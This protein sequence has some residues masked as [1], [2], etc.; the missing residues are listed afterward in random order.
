[1]IGTNIDGHGVPIPLTCV[2]LPNITPVLGMA[3]DEAPP[4]RS[5]PQPPNDLESDQSHD[6]STACTNITF[7]EV[8][9]SER[10]ETES[11]TDLE[12]TRRQRKARSSRGRLWGQLR[13]S[14]ASHSV[15]ATLAILALIVAAIG[16]WPS[17]SSQDDSK[18]SIAL[19]HW[20]AEKD[21]LEFCENVSFRLLQKR[22]LSGARVLISLTAC[23][24]YY[25]M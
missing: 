4:D 14:V 1:L 12:A 10:G 8:D 3:T 5:K 19:A 11:C 2:L 13:I 9:L 21:F 17:M 23:V 20:E 7:L 22:A 16:L 24:E 18:K 6:G 25:G 15:M